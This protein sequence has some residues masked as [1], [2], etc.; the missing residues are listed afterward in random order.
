MRFTG[1]RTVAVGL[2][3]GGY[4]MAHSMCV[5][6]FLGAKL[7]GSPLVAYDLAPGV[8]ATLGAN[9]VI[10]LSWTALCLGVGIFTAG[11]VWPA[12][13]GV[14][15]AVIDELASGISHG[16]K[17]LK[18]RYDLNIAVRHQEATRDSQ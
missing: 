2:G 6:E 15:Y 12:L 4:L 9:T 5:L 18:Q 3:L 11:I 14:F 17:N 1:I 16:L 7:T 10:P 8:S 13:E